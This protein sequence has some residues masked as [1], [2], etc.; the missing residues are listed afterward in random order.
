M[1]PLTAEKQI[2]LRDYLVNY[3]SLNTN[4]DGLKE[5]MKEYAEYDLKGTDL[6]YL[7]EAIARPDHDGF[8]RLVAMSELLQYHSNFKTTNGS[9]WCRDD[10]S[11]LGKKYILIRPKDK[12]SISGLKL[13]GF[14][15]NL[16][17]N[18]IIRADIQKEITTKRCVILDIGTNV[19]CD[20]K[21]GKKDD[22]RMNDKNS[23]KMEDF[24]PLCKTANDA[25]RSHC[26]RCKVTGKRYD[27]KRLGYS[28]SFTKGDFDTNNCQGCYWYD[29]VK[30]N[31]EISAAFKKNK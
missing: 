24:M 22:W 2:K 19:E 25:K 5:Y 23:Q 9:T 31:A 8:S 1:Y 10:Q 12:G 28:E 15:K 7:F 21:D 13:E 6:G 4:N 30:F 29:P 27:A 11:Y 14:N 17:I 18:Q 3:D 16:K 20:H 26:L